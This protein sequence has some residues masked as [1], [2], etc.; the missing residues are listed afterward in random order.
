[1]AHARGISPVVVLT[2]PFEFVKGDAP[3]GDRCV[4]NRINQRR[5][6]SVCRFI[7][8]NADRFSAVSFGA[9]A[10]RWLQDGELAAPELEA[11]LFPVLRRIVEN[12]AN[13]YLRFL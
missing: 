3:G 5:L 12:V 13:D 1:L 9:A 4:A 2:H 11:P 7:A 6:Q 8:E 10:S